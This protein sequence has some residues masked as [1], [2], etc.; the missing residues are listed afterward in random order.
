[1]SIP[2]NNKTPQGSRTP[3]DYTGA[4]SVANLFCQTLSFEA[5]WYPSGDW[6]GML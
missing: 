2:P 4:S 1:M 6:E 3:D 5:S